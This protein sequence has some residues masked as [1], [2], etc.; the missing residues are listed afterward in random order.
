[1]LQWSDER[2]SNKEL[3]MMKEGDEDL[4]SSTKF[5]SVTIIMLLMMLK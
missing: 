5:G 1:M 3:V 2:Y 4:K